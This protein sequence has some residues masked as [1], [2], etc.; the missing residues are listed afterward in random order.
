MSASTDTRLSPRSFQ[1][2]SPFN[3]PVT[4]IPGQNSLEFLRKVF[5]C[6]ETGRI[7]AIT[8]PGMEL[9]FPNAG[10]PCTD[11]APSRATMGWCRISHRPDTREQPAQITLTSGTEGRP[12]AILLSHRN[13]ADVVERLNTVMQVTSEIREYVGIPVY[14]SFGLGRIRA[15]SAAGG[16]FYLPQAFDPVEIRRL[17]EADEINA[18][19]AV[20]SLWRL[21]MANPDIIGTLGQK[22]RWIEIGSQYMSG[23]EKAVLKALF[24][25]ACIVQHYG[26]TEASRS[27]FLTVSAADDAALASVGK[28]TGTVE[29]AV[30]DEG[31]IHIRGP[32]VAMGLITPERHLKPLAGPDGWLRTGDRGRLENGYLHYEGRID[33]Q[34]N[35]AG[36]KINAETIE[37]GIAALVPSGADHFAIVGIP[38]PLRGEVVLMCVEDAT[39]APAP[40][41]AAAAAH[42]LETHGV[43]A[44]GTLRIA[45]VDTLPR[46]ETGKIRRAELRRLPTEPVE[47]QDQACKVGNPDMQPLS[48]AETVVADVWQKIVGNVRILPDHTFYD[49]GGDSL[50][51][52]QLALTMEGQGFTPAATR[53]TFEGGTVAEVARANAAESEATDDSGA[54]DPPSDISL[55]DQTQRIWGLAMTRAVAVLSVL[56]SHWGEGFF[57]RL[58][59]GE[60]TDQYLPVLYRLGTPGFA[61]VFGIGIGMTML[62]NFHTQRAAVLRRSRNAFLLV[63][64]GI[65][66]LAIVSVLHASLKG[67]D[68]GGRLLANAVYNVLVFYAIMLGTIWL[69]MPALARLKFPVQTLPLMAIAVWLLWPAAGHVLPEQPLDSFLELPRLMVVAG[70]SVFKLSAPMLIGIAVGLWVAREDDTRLVRSRLMATGFAGMAFCATTVL[71]FE[72]PESIMTRGLPVFVS[73]PGYAFYAS[74]MIALLGL[75]LYLTGA[76]SKLSR[77]TLLALRML[78]VIGGLALPIYVFHG[79]VIPIMHILILIGMDNV[80]ALILPLG[81]FLVSMAYAGQW[82]YRMYFR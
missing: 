55:R 46:T 16:A 23:Q 7:F 11:V 42:V 30:D 81:V 17:L 32:H 20:P 40:V 53:A 41:L 64:V 38:D 50:G 72:G 67:Q 58:G 28:P 44:A 34:I 29:V 61:T 10:E 12:K 2:E 3:E 77:P 45:H 73:P 69:W 57:H 62:P 27:T 47:A 70:Y 25:R 78:I 82:L 43:S 80:P 65:A 48:S 76:W 36:I 33:A 18:I 74:F 19:S 24:P 22:V 63:S 9:P 60:L 21:V 75:S 4:Q 79:L 1:D 35:I 37:S 49:I 5:E 39:E 31:V 6:Y 15:V 56:L 8:K 52:L 51:A 54:T 26:M 13:L 71:W 59:L 68:I 14:Y 66:L